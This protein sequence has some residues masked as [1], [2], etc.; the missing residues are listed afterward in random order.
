VITSKIETNFGEG[1]FSHHQARP[2]ELGPIDKAIL[3]FWTQSFRVVHVPFTFCLNTWTGCAFDILWPS[4]VLY[5]RQRKSPHSE[6][7]EV[8]SLALLSIVL[9]YAA[10]VLRMAYVGGSVLKELVASKFNICLVCE[11]FILSV[12]FSKS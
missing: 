10:S 5:T 12:L 7:S 4:L 8:R 1:I 11:M 2:T 3:M 6:W 9:G